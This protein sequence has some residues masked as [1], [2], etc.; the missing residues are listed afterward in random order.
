MLQYSNILNLLLQDACREEAAK[1]TWSNGVNP[2]VG[3]QPPLPKAT[4]RQ[5]GQKMEGGKGEKRIIT[6]RG[7]LESTK[8]VLRQD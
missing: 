6:K 4:A 3:G 1:S 7:N 2:E 8:N 5:G